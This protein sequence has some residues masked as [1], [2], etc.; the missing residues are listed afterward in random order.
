MK[1][2]RQEGMRDET[3]P[4]RLEQRNQ[5]L[6]ALKLWGHCGQRGLTQLFREPG[7]HPKTKQVL[8]CIPLLGE[9]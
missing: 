4:L 8:E 1:A 3:R 9:G 2:L 6:M 7:L 5:R